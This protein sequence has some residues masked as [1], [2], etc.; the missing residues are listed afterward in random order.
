MINEANESILFVYDL[1]RKKMLQVNAL[2][3][4]SKKKAFLI[5]IFVKKNDIGCRI[6]S[7]KTLVKQARNGKLKNSKKYCL[8]PFFC[9][10]IGQPQYSM[11]TV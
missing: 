1:I 5:S 3:R 2:Q 10:Y 8:V 4:R 9:N 7:D 11:S 6:F